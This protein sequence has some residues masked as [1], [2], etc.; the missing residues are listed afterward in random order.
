[1]RFIPSKDYDLLKRQAYALYTIVQGQELKLKILRSKDYKLR[2]EVIKI[3]K[4]MIDS[5]KEMNNIL[6]RELE[7]EN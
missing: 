4:E 6:M 5:E 3:L 7:N 1:M 2:P